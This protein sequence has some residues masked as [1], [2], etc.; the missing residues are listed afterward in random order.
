MSFFIGL[1]VGTSGAKALLI[2]VKGEV[3]TSSTNEYPMFTPKPNWTEQNPTDWW[4][5]SKKSINEVA[6]KVNKDEIRAI[7]LTG[8]MHGLVI[9]DSSGNVV[10]PC[11]MWN[12]QRT[13]KECEEITRKVGFEKLIKITGNQVLTGFTAPKILWIRNNEP[14]NYNKIAKI[15]LPKDYIRFRLTGELA[16]DVSD[17]SGTSLLNVR[18]RQWSDEIL[19]TLEIPKEW[20]PQLYESTEVTG[21]I[22]HDISEE[23]NLPNNLPVAAGGGDQAAGGIGTGTVEE[24]IT[25]LVL[26]TSGVVFAHTDK[27]RIEKE[28]KVHSFCH[29]VPDAWHI[30]G[31]TL[32]AAGSLQWYR[33]TFHKDID[34]SEL[35]IEAE[36]IITGSEG[37][38]FL[39]Y[40][41]GERTPHPDPNAKGTFI[42]ATVRHNS[43]HFTRSVLEGVAYSLR[44]CF[45]I[46][47]SLGVETSQVRISGGGAR[48]KLWIQ[49]LSD[50]LNSEIVTPSST[51]GAPYGAAIL[52]AAA[53]GDF[54]SVNEACD[55]MLKINEIAT[56][57][58]ENI[59][60]Y[61]DYYSIYK[62]LYS[63]LKST[64]ANISSTVERYSS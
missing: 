58:K 48:S 60:I 5:A 43:A 27:P 51:E 16:T 47:K 52:A 10:R 30:M 45:E 41:S 2:N 20:V 34:Y 53:T 7:G 13:I 11:I 29:A 22:K 9:L 18:E 26:G 64:F 28:G 36:K 23:L 14:E 54:N 31:V 56:P 46:N 6:S 15:L 33:N 38:F 62:N 39:P 21:K 3:I 40:L 32:S 1:D 19:S 61:E 50:L 8:Q 57:N 17:A 59:N 42:G 44:D 63:T 24:G 37:L 12:D 25:S 49:I 35:T 4:E 55:S